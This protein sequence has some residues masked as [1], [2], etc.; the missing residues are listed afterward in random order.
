MSKRS[1]TSSCQKKGIKDRAHALE[2]NNVLTVRIP[3]REDVRGEEKRGASHVHK[4]C[5]TRRLRVV[6]YELLS[7]VTSSFV[8]KRV[9]N[10]RRLLYN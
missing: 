3:H 6:V 2:V 8:V 5:I 10:I 1:T 9:N 7:P 4:I